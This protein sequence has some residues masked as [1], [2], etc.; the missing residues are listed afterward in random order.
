MG[1]G[2]GGVEG[3]CGVEGGGMIWAVRHTAFESTEE[4]LCWASCSEHILSHQCLT[5][6]NHLHHSFQDHPPPKKNTQGAL[7]FSV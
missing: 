5:R 2:G 7:Q 4:G 1:G 6:V 3:G